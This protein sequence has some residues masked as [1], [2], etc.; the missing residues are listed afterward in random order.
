MGMNMDYL[1]TFR[2]VAKWNSFTKAGEMLGYAQSSVTTQIKKLEEEFGVILFERWGG[3]IKLTQAGVQL[4]EYT[5]KIISLLEEAKQNLSE[6][7]EL[8]GT[9]SI[10]TIESIAGFYL[11]PYLQAFKNE[12]PKVNLLLQQGICK[13]LLKGIKEGKYD[14][15]IILDQKQE[16]PDLNFITIKEEQLVLVAKPDHHLVQFS[17]VSIKDLSGEK[18]IVTEQRCSYR[19]II[20]NLYRSHA[21]RLEYSIELESIE[22]IKRCVSYGLGI[23]FLPLMTVDEEIKKG[24]LAYIPLS[25]PEIKVY[26]QLVYHK[27]KWISQSTQ[28]LINLLLE[29]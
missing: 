16:D 15:A 23:A 9:L 24:E 20:E 18:L 7:I 11:P 21:I 14:L 27:K 3:K 29:S 4:L 22:A 28:R 1:Q 2:E 19:E 12:H 13:D 26:L 5:N 10:G 6:Q 8:S 25:Y 17:N